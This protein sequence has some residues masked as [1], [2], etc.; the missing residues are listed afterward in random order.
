MVRRSPSVWSAQSLHYSV[1]FAE[2]YLSRCRHCDNRAAIG[3]I[4]IFCGNIPKLVIIVL[5]LF[6][7]R[8]FCF[9]F[10]LF[11]FVC[12]PVCGMFRSNLPKKPNQPLLL[13]KRLV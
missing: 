8:P 5:V 9:F 10:W 7:F 1:S 13:Q 2:G 4:I 11:G 3:L 12:V 6:H